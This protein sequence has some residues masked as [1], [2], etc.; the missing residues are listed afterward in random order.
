MA[1][2]VGKFGFTISLHR[3]NYKF[4]VVITRIR[5]D[6]FRMLDSLWVLPCTNTRH[7]LT[8]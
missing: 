4:V 1:L 6:S 3:H 8:S 2:C 5:H 7:G